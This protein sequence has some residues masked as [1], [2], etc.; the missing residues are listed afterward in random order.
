MRPSRPLLLVAALRVSTELPPAALRVPQLEAEA[1]WMAW[2]AWERESQV[3]RPPVEPR[4]CA[5]R[6]GQVA[7]ERVQPKSKVRSRYRYRR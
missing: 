3:R 2:M 6:F 7:F 4:W 1:A 5:A